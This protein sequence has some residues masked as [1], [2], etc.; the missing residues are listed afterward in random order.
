MSG[1]GNH[2]LAASSDGQSA[3]SNFWNAR[4]YDLGAIAVLTLFFLI[5]FQP[6]LFHGR[7]FVTSDAFIYSYPL[8]T[9]VWNELSHGRLPL[10]T[11]H[12]MSG[13]PLLSMA[14]IGVGY[15]LTWFYAFLPGR[16][17]ETIYDLTPFLLFPIF[18]YCYLREV[19]RSRLGSILGAL[20]FSYG[21]FLIS[22]V[23][24]N[25]L[26]ANALMWLP[27]MLIA[28]ERARRRPFVRCLLGATG[29]YAMSVLTGVGQGFLLTGAIALAYAVFT[30]LVLPPARVNET[31][32]DGKS[33]WRWP[34]W[35]PLAVTLCAITL[36]AGVS[37]FQI[38]E[39][40]R[41]QRRSI[42][43]VLSYDLFAFGSSTPAH[44][45]KAFFLP[46]HYHLEASGYVAPLI[47]LLAIVAIVA[48][49]RRSDSDRRAFFWLGMAAAGFVL[50]MGEHTPIFRLLYYLPFFSLFR[51]AAR[52]AFEL[53][54]GISVLAAYGW[55]SASAIATRAHGKVLSE[56]SR[57]HL[58]F[59]GL[60]IISSLL[61]GA[62]WLRD[63]A[64]VPVGAMEIYYYPPS[65][66][67]LRYAIWKIFF[68][69]LTLF[70][71]WQAG[72]IVRARS[73]TGLLLAVI[74]LACF[75]E[76]AIMVSRWWWPTLKPAERFT[77]A[78]PTTRLLQQYPPEQN[79]VYTRVYPFIEEYVSQPR[80]EP[81]NLTVIHGL[82]NTGGYEPLILERYS[83]A[84][85]NVYLD[86]FRPRPGYQEERSLLES[87]SH[88]LDLLN[89]RFLVSYSDLATEPAPRIEKEE[90]KFKARDLDL[91]LK[92]GEAANL[93]GAAARADV[94][95]LVT[96]TAY[97]AE[98]QDGTPVARVRL[99]S[100][101]GKTLEKTLRIGVDTAEWAHDH[102]DVK[103]I[104]R[105]SL[106]PVFESTINEAG[107][108]A[109]RF[110]ARVPLD[111]PV[112]VDRIE[113][114]NISS[115]VILIVSRATLFDSANKFSMPLPHYDLNKW[116]PVYDRE[117]ALVLRNKQALPR[118]WLVAEAESLDGE[119]ALRRIRG[120]G[121]AFDPRRTALL[122]IQPRN[123][124][125][126]PGG[127]ISPGAAAR[128]VAYE[129]NRLVIE[130]AAE[131]AS[132]LVVSEINY[133][134]WIATIDGAKAPIHTTDFLLRGIVLPAGSHRVEM[135]YT[136]PAAR[137]G[138][139]ISVSTILL[140]GALAFYERRRA[141][142]AA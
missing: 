7:F 28:I 77:V 99:F 1:S 133:P 107:E 41:A 100:S 46:L 64:R 68:S 49:M 37:A 29:A 111:A 140:I 120:E 82:Q 44:A 96:A 33:F 65:Y 116:A 93:K 114:T 87:N 83:R 91:T 30:G 81:M 36:S 136:A 2:I 51:G 5:F 13:Y 54:L 85:G 4:R 40:L 131:T 109:Y 21:G 129:N 135:R 98:E 52:H 56:N 67:A 15:P 38:L 106:A 55:D 53:T 57:R 70:A 58:L 63:V 31:S 6:A 124:P 80:L 115:R 61:L 17:A 127:P 117:S 39:T 35:R 24:Y 73:R 142:R 79:R 59:A 69:L 102:A 103:P 110:I 92:P 72:K 105:H 66:G 26:L 104:V 112:Q 32:D 121:A 8:R 134:G 88:V 22:S 3:R 74:A 118:A 138:A 139:L 84:L 128:I 62:L 141:S 42:R 86:A 25:G 11:P 71:F 122:E 90:I 78:S 125:A 47:L 95:C 27:L 75:F 126:L 89:T 43:K 48:A 60:A 50:M 19:E 23:T 12:I 101:E 94:L 132:V 76:P 14:Q 113:I 137:N 9:L 34:R 45:A 16:F 123:L 10:W 119:E 130:T 108:S 20:A 97:S 18:I